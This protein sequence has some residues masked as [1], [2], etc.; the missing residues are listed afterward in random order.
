MSAFA[1]AQEVL[2][3]ADSALT[4]P[5]DRQ[6]VHWGDIAVDCDQL[7]VG[8][9][10]MTPTQQFPDAP[11]TRVRC[12]QIP[13]QE[14]W[15]ELHRCGPQPD[16]QGNAPPPADLQVF[17]HTMSDDQEALVCRFLEAITKN[18]MT[19]RPQAWN[20]QPSEPLGPQG[21]FSGVRLRL[22]VQLNCVGGG[23]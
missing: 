1:I 13:V 19:T 23:S 18:E 4:N 12:A 2:D 6:Y 20:M 11:L 10:G 5:P 14:Y 22:S 15:V 8:I 9:R 7:V 21:G 16:E 3:V 17:A